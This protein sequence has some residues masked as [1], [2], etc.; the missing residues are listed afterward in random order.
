MGTIGALRLYVIVC[1]NIKISLYFMEMFSKLFNDLGTF[2]PIILI[3]P[4]MYLLWNK[5]NLFFYYTSGV[6]IG[7]ILNVV[8]KGLF[9]QPRPNI[10]QKS[11]D[12]ALK[13]GKRLLFKDGMPYYIFGMPSGHSQ[14]TFFSTIFIYFA[15]R[16]NNITYI[17]LAI[18]L[19]TIL[20]RVIYNHHTVLQVIVGALIGS[21]VGYLFYYLATENVKGL[22][23]EKLD[24]FGPL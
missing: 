10:D 16:K 3:V 15:L 14:S 1:I 21:A 9:Q 22:I 23:R 5:K 8:L 24:D 11:F 12:L 17:Y 13:N 2:G 20:Q 19:L 7:N 6:L 4:S 18:S